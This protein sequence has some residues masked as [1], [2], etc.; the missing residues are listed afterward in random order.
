VGLEW[1]SPQASETTGAHFW[2]VGSNFGDASQYLQDGSLVI[3]FHEEL[4][5]A[6]KGQR[7]E[8]E[9]GKTELRRNSGKLHWAT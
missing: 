9:R 8:H 1:T 5:A 3:T 2:E 4:S 6:L 7:L